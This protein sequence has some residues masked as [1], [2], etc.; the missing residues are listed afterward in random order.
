MTR[1]EFIDL[2]IG[3][4]VIPVCGNSL[5]KGKL[6]VVTDIKPMDK[7]IRKICRSGYVTAMILD[8]EF[9]GGHIDDY[10]KKTLKYRSWKK[11]SN[12]ISKFL[13]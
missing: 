12:F 13:K 11:R 10:G 1:E 8:G 6:C 4:N 9:K 7:D 5:D 2:E 3:D